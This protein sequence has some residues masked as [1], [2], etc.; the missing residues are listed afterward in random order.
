GASDSMDQAVLADR[1]VWEL[2]PGHHFGLETAGRNIVLTPAGVRHVEHALGVTNLFDAEHLDAHAAVQDALHAHVLLRRDVDYVVHNGTVLSVDEFKGRIVAERRWPAG[3]QTALECKEGV[4]LRTQGRVL[5]SITVENLVALYARVAG[6]TGT[7]ATQAGEFREIYGLDVVSIPTHR[8]VARVDHPDWI[9]ATK[10][11][12]EAAV[13]EEIRRRHATGQP[14]L[15][16]TA[17][18]EE[19]ERVSRRLGA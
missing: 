1:A 4:R 9:F 16:G 3:L 8:P 12:K 7:A 5:G 13:V 19:S 10:A 14:V 18:V 2:L 6:M 17:S 11:D 15:V